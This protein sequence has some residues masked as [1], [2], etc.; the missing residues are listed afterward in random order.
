M[1][2]HIKKY[3]KPG[4]NM[5]DVGSYIGTASLMMSEVIDSGCKIYAFEPLYNKV[6]R[7]N[8]VN[9]GKEDVISLY[10]C[11]LGE[12]EYQVNKP[13]V[14]VGSDGNYGGQ[15]I[16]VFHHGYCEEVGGNGEKIDIRRL[17]SFGFDNVSLIKIDV[18]GFELN[19]LAGAVE[20]LRR[21]GFPTIIIEIWENDGWR[22]STKQLSDFYLGRKKEIID[23]LENLGYVMTQVSYYDFVC[24]HS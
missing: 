13:V 24:V 17:D 23:F 6:T 11:G 2:D 22:G 7:M 1:M 8:I 16:A 20:T 14:N 21:N 18:E 15:A 5:I 19:V 12:G 10:E 4:T 3:Y 9:N